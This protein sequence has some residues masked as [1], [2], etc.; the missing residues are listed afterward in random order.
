MKTLLKN[1]RVWQNKAF[2]PADVL[3]DGEII[4]QVAG[5]IPPADADQA[6]D[7]TGRYLVPGLIEC[8]AHL[9]MNGGNSP[10]SVMY[11][12][13]TSQ[14]LMEC[15]TSMR[16]L[17]RAGITTVR[18]CGSTGMEV[19][20]LRDEVNRGRFVGPRIVACGM[21][22]KMTGGHFTG[23][24]VDS[25]NQARRAARELIRDGAQF[26]KFMGS[27]GLGHGGEPGV[28][29]LEVEEMRAAIAQGEKHH[30]AAAVHCH[31]KQ[32]IL[33]ALEAGATSIEHCSFM[34]GEVIERLLETGAFIVPTFTPYVRIEENGV[35]PDTWLTPD[36]VRMAREVN[37]RKAR[38]FSDAYHAGV[39]IAFGRDA[40]A[41]YTPHE[42]FLFE[43][44]QMESCGM[45]RADILHS[46]TMAAA[47]N[48]RMQRQVGSLEPGKYADLLVL[49]NNPMDDLAHLTC[50]ETI[51]K[52]GAA[53]EG[54]SSRR[55]C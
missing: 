49:R 48:L 55:L 11:R 52:A 15:I 43:M 33:N 30:L 14:I 5:G 27:G 53:I 9:C 47:E 51:W 35:V 46:A 21:A 34:D 29:E 18:D 22:I 37:E 26:L 40:G 19:I 3:I 2:E 20:A 45:S 1:A 36:T 31:G 8:H 54:I 24:V 25:P 38:Q 12:S 41:T 23:K 50:A 7:L 13:N 44:R 4:E 28:A 42:D 16:R 17:L 32:S 39:P 6:L 10:M